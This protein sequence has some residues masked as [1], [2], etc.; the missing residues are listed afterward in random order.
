[1]KFILRYTPL[2]ADH[3]YFVAHG[4]PWPHRPEF[5]LI[6]YTT[7][8]RSAAKRFDTHE[9]ALAALKLSDDPIGWDI[10]EVGE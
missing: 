5:R 10:D 2:P 4:V 3:H 7:T 1:M 6:G 8:D 9:E